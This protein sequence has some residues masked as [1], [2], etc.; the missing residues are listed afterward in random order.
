MRIVLPIRLKPQL[1]GAQE[2][3]L[4][5]RKLQ[6]K[7][8][9][10]H[11]ELNFFEDR[12]FG[13]ELRERGYGIKVVSSEALAYD[14]NVNKYSDIYIKTPA[15]EYLR[16]INKKTFALAYSHYT[17]S[18]F[19]SFIRFIKSENGRMATFHT[20]YVSLM[21]FGAVLSLILKELGIAMTVLGLTIVSLWTIGMR[22]R[23]CKDLKETLSCLFKYSI[24]GIYSFFP[25]LYF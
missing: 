10:F 21:F 25:Y 19:N 7:E 20:L 11:N 2:H 13:Y 23:R 12:Y 24:F 14:I 15:K 18:L 17:D 8:I 4:L 22:I 5:P 1:G 9:K 3:S 6:K 16:A